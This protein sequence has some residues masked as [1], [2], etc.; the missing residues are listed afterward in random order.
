MRCAQCARRPRSRPSSSSRWVLVSVRR[1]PSS[2]SSMRFGSDSTLV[3]KRIT[4][5]GAAKTV[6]GILPLSF[7]LYTRDVDVWSPAIIREIPKYDNRANHVLRVVARL[8]RGFGVADAQ[9]DMRRVAAALAAE[10]AKEDQGWTANAF[11]M[12]DE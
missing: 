11:S 12:R 2:A 5:N 6:I 3:G 1:A 10:Y 7:R 9:R 4:L 8:R